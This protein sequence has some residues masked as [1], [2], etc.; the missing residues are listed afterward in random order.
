MILRAGRALCLLAPALGVL[1]ALA[2]AQPRAAVGSTAR[3]PGLIAY[4]AVG[5]GLGD[6]GVFTIRS[7]GTDGRMI[8]PGAF[9]P[10]WSADGQRLLYQHPDPEQGLWSALAD[11]SDARPIIRPRDPPRRV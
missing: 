1:L 11:G 10:E 6:S 4:Y 3:T 9:D 8:L 5:P 7:D 2:S